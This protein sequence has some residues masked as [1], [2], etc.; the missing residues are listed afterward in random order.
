M[1]NDLKYFAFIPM[2][3]IAGALVSQLNS[4]GTDELFFSYR[5]TDIDIVTIYKGIMIAFI[6]AFTTLFVKS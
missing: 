1:D 2:W 6:V 3:L 4:S 5:Y